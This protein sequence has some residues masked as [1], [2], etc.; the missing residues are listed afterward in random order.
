MTETNVDWN[1]P[2]TPSVGDEPSN[3]LYHYT[4][5][6]VA[7]FN[8]LTSGTLRL[9]P[10]HATNDPWETEPFRP[11]FS[12]PPDDEAFGSEFAYGAWGD[13]DRDIRLHSKIVSLTQDWTPRDAFAK[14]NSGWSHLSS[15]AHYGAR[16]TG[17]CLGF[18]R[19][20]LVEEFNKIG[21]PDALRF[22][23][24]VQYWNQDQPPYLESISSEQLKLYGTDAVARHYAEKHHKT[25]FLTK[26]SDW[27]PEYEYR[28]A[29]MNGSALPAHI[30]IRR[31]LTTVVVGSKF[32]DGLTPALSEALSTYQSYKVAKLGLQSRFTIVLPFPLS[33]EGVASSITPALPG[34]LAYRLEKL[35]Q[36]A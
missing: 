21:G 32:S 22:H 20:I 34:D 6:E 30:D 16:Q 1:T 18:D 11:S 8:I 36:A 31:A 35:R 17:I 27:A 7:I 26:H 4:S 3:I 24:P 10:M 9:S 13:I 12:V 28:F 29:I 25:V 2:A 15:W 33:E 23:G 14:Q 19:T 5:A